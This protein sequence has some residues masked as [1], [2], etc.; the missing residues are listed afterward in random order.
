MET[1]VSVFDY[2]GD[3]TDLDQSNSKLKILMMYYE[4]FITKLCAVCI[5][6][7]CV[8]CGFVIELCV[9]YLSLSYV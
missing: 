2:I 6:P 8:Q 3:D 9:M 7:N 5:P 4:I 1:T